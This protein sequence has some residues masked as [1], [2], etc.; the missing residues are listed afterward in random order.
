MIRGLIGFSDFMIMGKGNL[1]FVEV[2]LRLTK[3]KYSPEQLSF[4]MGIENVAD[5]NPFV[6]YIKADETN[7]NL[8]H[9]YILTNEFNKL[10]NL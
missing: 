2:K 6:F 4:K 10:K 8:I 3:D 7:F 1:F 5:K 9:E